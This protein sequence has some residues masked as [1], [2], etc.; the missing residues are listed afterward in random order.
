MRIYSAG[1]YRAMTNGQGRAGLLRCCCHNNGKF[2]IGNRQATI[3]LGEVNT[4]PV[5]LARQ[6]ISRSLQGRRQQEE[7]GL[8]VDDTPVYGGPCQSL[9]DAQ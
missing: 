8:S 2:R 4:L 3:E 6:R 5:P 9:C 1:I 7:R